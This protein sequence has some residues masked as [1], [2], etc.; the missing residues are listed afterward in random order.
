MCAVYMDTPPP[1]SPQA[2]RPAHSLDRVGGAPSLGRGRAR[3]RPQ[4][5]GETVIFL[6]PGGAI[7][8]NETARV[9]FGSEPNFE[10]LGARPKVGVVQRCIGD[11]SSIVPV[12]PRFSTTALKNMT[13]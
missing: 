8:T 6:N 2:S 5:I 4:E 13:P 7:L 9:E 10:A 1:T 3:G 12:A 11:S